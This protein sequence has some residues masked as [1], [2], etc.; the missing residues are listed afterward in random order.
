M[1]QQ[2]SIPEEIKH[3][4]RTGGALIQLI[5]INIIVFLVINIIGVVGRLSGGDTEFFL[6]KLVADIFA[7]QTDVGAF[8][9]HPWGIFT[10]IF[11]HQNFLHFLFNMLIFYQSGRM[12]LQFF[13]QK[14]LVYTYILGGLVGGLFEMASQV[15]PNIGPTISIGASG[16]VMA[17][18]IAVAAHK[19]RL[20]LSL[21]G[22]INIPLYVFAGIIF[23]LDFISLGK[24]DGT[25]HF[26]HVGGAV[27]GFI[28]VQQLR[29]SN[30]II[31]MAQRFG[32]WFGRLFRKK[33]KLSVEK[34]DARRMSD[35]DYNQDKKMRQEKID[36]ILDKIS[37]SGYESLSRDEKDFLFKQSK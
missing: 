31:N 4:Y 27:L 10:H 32:D 28:S 35:E 15:F 18:L 23:I 30:N 19:P 12:F 3:Q 33:P 9:T 37:K 11:S 36:R 20:N 25:A 34:G 21:F 29:S 6:V 2:R 13:S 26:S 8:A 17:V 5:F 7:L 16:A 1:Q 22:A 24:D 14:R